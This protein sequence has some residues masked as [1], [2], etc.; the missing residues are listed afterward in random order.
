MARCVCRKCQSDRLVNNGSAAGNPK[1]L[2]QQCGYQ[3]PRTTPRGPPL[4][5]KINAVLCS[6]SGISMNR[7]AFLLQVSAQSVL[8]RIRAF[9]KEQDEKPE[10][11]G[12]TIVLELDEMWHSLKQK[13][14]KLWIWKALDCT[15]GQLLDWECGRRDKATLKELVDRLAP[16]A[17]KRYCTDRWATSTSVIPQDKLVQSKATTHAIERNPCRQR[18]WFGRFKRKAMIVSKSK[19]NGVT[20]KRCPVL[21]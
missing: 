5:T 15:T 13:R 1:K 18:Q 6:L 14:R 3:F 10:P 4:K 21:N 20:Q 16:W 11:A 19:E 9:A 7:L 17:V 2:C 12:N 8:N